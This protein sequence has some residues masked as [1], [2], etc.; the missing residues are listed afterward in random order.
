MADG[1]ILFLR[2]YL[3]LAVARHEEMQARVIELEVLI[4]DP[5]TLP[6]RREAYTRELHRLRLS[7]GQVESLRTEKV[8]EYDAARAADPMRPLDADL[9][10]VLFPVRI[11]TA[12]LPGDGGTDLVVRVYPDDVHVD[13]HQ[14]E[15]SETE[16][17][18]GTA[19]WRAIWGAGSNAARIKAAW[20][21]LTG[22]IRPPRAAFVVQA[23]APDVARPATEIPFDREQPAPPVRT[24]ATRANGSRTGARVTLLPHHWQIVGL[25]N[26]TLLFSVDGPPISEGLEIGLRA[27]PREGDTASS[28]LPLSDA[29][30]WL[31]DLNAALA[32]GMAV[33]I[34]L[35]D[36]DRSVD[37]LFVFGVDTREG[38]EEA[39]TRVASLLSA[40]YYTNGLAFLPPGTPTNNTSATRSAWDSTT[41]PASPLE[42]AA[43][44]EQ[45]Q[46]RSFQNAA[47]TASA[48]G[49]DGRD[50]LSVL[51]HALEDQQS[52]VRTL[53][54]Q[55]WPVV[56]NRTLEWI[57]ER[58]ESI[59]GG[60]RFVWHN[61]DALTG[62]LATHAASWLRSR[63]TLPVMRIGNQPYGLLP[64]TSLAT[65]T[66]GPDDPLA[67]LVPWLRMLRNYWL[68]AVER[69]PH[70]VAGATHDP[71]RTIQDLFARLSVSRNLM[72]RDDGD[73][74]NR[75]V[76]GEPFPLA[77]VPQLPTDS[78]LFFATPA[79]VA[80]PL[81]VPIVDAPEDDVK[82]LR[83]A[84]DWMADAVAYFENRMSFDSF[85]A[86]Y[87]PLFA[88]GFFS[89]E[90][91]SDLYT[92]LIYDSL[93]DPLAGA[94]QAWALPTLVAFA[95]E[96][97]D[98]PAVQARVDV[99]LPIAR[100][101]LEQFER[102]CALDPRRSE[103]LLME[104]LDVAS[105][106]LDAW[107]TSV[108]ARRLAELRSQKP[109]GVIVGAYG[110][111][112]DL[113][114]RTDLQRVELPPVGHS[115]A[116]ASDRQVYVH[117][118]S[119]HHAATAAVLRAGYDSHPHEEVLAVNLT[120][121]RVRT[122]QWL[123]EGARNGQTVG[124]L[125]G[126]RF[127]RALHDRH[128]DE[129][130]NLIPLLRSQY[131]LPLPTETDGDANAS[132]AR[133]A[134]AARNVVD[135]L[136]LFKNRADLKIAHPEA[137]PMLDA[138]AD[139]I[140]SLG[141]LLLAESV[142]HLVGGNPMRAGV[143]ADAIGR[144]E[145]VPDR[146]DVVRTPR[147]GSVL[148]WQLGVLLDVS[149]G[150]TG[151]WRVDS[152]RAQAAP[153][154]NRWVAAM[155]GDA[156]RWKISCEITTA[157]G[158]SVFDA[159]G[160]DALGISALDAIL[161]AAGDQSPLEERVLD[162]IATRYPG[163]LAVT[164]S[165]SVASADPG[166]GELLSLAGRLRAVLAA[167][168]PLGPQQVERVDASPVRG[169]DT[170]DL[171]RRAAALHMSLKPAYEE[172]DHAV[173]GLAASG[174]PPTAA[175]VHRVHQA[176]ARLATHGVALARP[177]RA[178][179]GDPDL[180]RA[181]VRHA[182][183]VLSAI[184]PLAT[185]L[186]PVLPASAPPAG[187]TLWLSAITKYI[188]DIIGS[189]VPVLPVFH[190]PRDS[191]YAAS[192]AEPPAAAEDA[193]VT[194]WL[195]RMARVRPKIWP[196]H[197]AL[198]ATML[199]GAP[200]TLTAVHLPPARGEQWAALQF[201][202]APL[203]A[204]VSSVFHTPTPIDPAAS[205]CGFVV[206]SWSER[207]PGLTHQQDDPQVHEPVELTGLAFTVEAPDACAPQVILL[208]VAPDLS[209]GWSI[210][211]L[212]DVLQ[213]TLDLAKTRTVDL[214]DLPRF[215]R[216]LPAIHSG[217]FTDAMFERAGLTL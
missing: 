11:E 3:R 103:S 139:A 58:W 30:L 138:L 159:L 10:L 67:R 161:E 151:G 121:G 205:F 210:D 93:V 84:R 209:K 165:H 195:R 64:A 171:A 134:I 90:Y 196:F 191:A 65:W 63:G 128:D 77:P 132:A 109:K 211:V 91:R 147:T 212:F 81:P 54:E 43:M 18:L 68:A 110:W 145:L 125:L 7:L 4:A 33:R 177:P 164:V 182:A 24:A 1:D 102:V 181:I 46:A 15:L 72:V 95:H 83:R 74:R 104:I 45:Y 38:P 19:Y 133:E 94:N 116:F 150:A 183:V 88:T 137:A 215:G 126:Y 9:P 193:A 34:P 208:G 101:Y 5:N 78:R 20:T 185:T 92:T 22:G 16:V 207:V 143:A 206:D 172:L 201:D 157:D 111:V 167:A 40:H 66:D 52:D 99:L 202:T 197:D 85:W 112:E 140:D 122:A 169:L 190:L 186:P 146:F 174:D 155:L 131:P 53:Q 6:Y 75:I 166:F 98:D 59:P 36:P 39:G 117:A 148:T 100:K 35:R 27:R 80:V 70:V 199:T 179:D 160:L 2:H 86:K 50:V 32:A 55:L 158:N 13:A 184:K 51:P 107:I 118:P 71:D 144:G 187:I 105:H 176:L 69:V 25:R 154:V 217:N 130:D 198:L 14:A 129:L 61:D 189:A 135:G 153:H 73:P 60:N 56:A 108:A 44:R 162:V 89:P 213:E 113:A 28:D 200:T 48:L 204:R 152:P 96:R 168:C 194:A 49:L 97:P 41:A 42:H 47:V 29:S 57:F 79:S 156:T 17:T 87:E 124:E 62:A 192:L 163:A 123:A 127:E 214:G 76:S 188:Q 37:Q 21:N 119:M 114:E 175:A 180:A 12:Y 149:A 31:V 136:A 203:R 82:L 142:H 23:L 178:T 106:R 141:D 173:S 120:S 115:E 26:A 216:L 8:A 170:D